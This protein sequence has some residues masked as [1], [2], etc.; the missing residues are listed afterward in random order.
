MPIQP[1][2]SWIMNFITVCEK[3]VKYSVEQLG[4]H[5]AESALPSTALRCGQPLTPT[6]RT[7]RR[8]SLVVRLVSRPRMIM[9]RFHNWQLHFIYFM[10]F[11]KEKYVSFIFRQQL[12]RS[13]L[14][15]ISASWQ[16]RQLP[17]L[18]SQQSEGREGGTDVAIWVC[19]IKF[20]VKNLK[21]RFFNVE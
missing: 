4:R 5:T 11:N 6:S 9:V 20:Y 21:K 8:S 19:C 15:L 12:D 14:S 18:W 10:I 1:P 7:A 16:F 2:T 3:S 17:Q 13:R